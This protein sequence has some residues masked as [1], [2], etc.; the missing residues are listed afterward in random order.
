MLMLMLSCEG[1]NDLYLL[2]Q[3]DSKQNVVDEMWE[4]WKALFVKM[5]QLD[6]KRIKKK[7]SV[8]WV[9]KEIKTK[10]FK[11]DFL[12]RK[13]IK[14]N[15]ENYWKLYKSSRNAANIALRSAKAE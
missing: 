1:L 3:L 2:A 10:L 6:K 8:P 13:A 14:I 11:R 5:P 4:C 12:K 15:D 7:G 9:N